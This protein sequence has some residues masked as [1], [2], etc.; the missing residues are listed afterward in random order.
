MVVDLLHE[1]DE[2]GP[3][4]MKQEQDELKP[5]LLDVML[6][7][8]LVDGLLDAVQLLLGDAVV[9]D[10]LLQVSMVHFFEVF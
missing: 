5:E 3:E 9:D 10:V 6:E 8:D 2:C 1:M 4:L 7:D